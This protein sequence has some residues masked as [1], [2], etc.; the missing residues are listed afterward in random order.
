VREA[1]G[2]RVR[3]IPVGINFES[4]R[5]FRSRVLVVFGPDVA[6]E[7][8]GP[9]PAPGDVEGLT[10]RVEEALRRLVPDLD[11]WEE[12]E[13]VRG[14]KDLYLGGRAGS[15]S[16]EAPAL[17]RFID[18]Y[19]GYREACP[20]RVGEIRA[21]WEAY[22]RQMARFSVTDPQLELA[23]SPVRA[24]RF[25]LGSALVIG[26]ALPLAAVGFVV[27]IVPFLL[28]GR[29]ERKLNR[30]PDLSATIKLLIGLVL[31]PLTYLV[32]LS[33]PF[34]RGGWRAALPGLVLLP[35]TGWAA[36]LMA[37]NRVRL[38]ESARALFIALPGGRP[39]TELRRERQKILEQV[40]RMIRERPLEAIAPPDGG[41][42]GAQR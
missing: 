18:G 21:R 2:G 3:M 7:D 24:A 27:H 20:A 41:A 25:L 16:E 40:T 30:H 9:P 36:L 15:L 17:R 34:I 33:F 22:R 26:L 39:L 32:V 14:I 4:K 11:S 6:G 31:F 13:F 19:R 29:L 5:T 37:E 10:R 8:P 28:T 12:L 1:E 23:D 38:E 42:E 35:L